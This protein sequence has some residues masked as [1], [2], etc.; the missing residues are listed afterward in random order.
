MINSL[1]RD[2]YWT[3]EE[4]MPAMTSDFLKSLGEG[5]LNFD[6]SCQKIVVKKTI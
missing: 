1:I 6:S 5:F 2:G 3:E 4:R